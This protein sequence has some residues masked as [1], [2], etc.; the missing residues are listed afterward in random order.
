[1][2]LNNTIKSKLILHLIEKAFP[3]EE[4]KQLEAEL[5]AECEKLPIL[6][7]RRAVLALAPGYIRGSSTTN[8]K[9]T[10]TEKG[11]S[12]TRNI[13]VTLSFSY[14]TKVDEFGALDIRIDSDDF[15]TAYPEVYRLAMKKRDYDVKKRSYSDNLRKI[16]EVQTSSTAVKKLIPE[17]SGFFDREDSSVGVGSSLID[18]SAVDF[19][20][21]CLRRS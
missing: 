5:R 18:M 10:S 9:Y 19:V 21:S 3:V 16:L 2:R 4:E 17:S 12:W 1:M 8:L 6:Q 11:Y 7:E 13:Q 15:K 20:N 14:A